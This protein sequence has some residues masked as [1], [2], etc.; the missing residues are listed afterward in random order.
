MLTRAGIAL[1]NA[2]A[3][4]PIAR[5]RAETLLGAFLRRV[6]EAR[7]DERW[8]HRPERVHLFGSFL[9]TDKPLV[10]DVDLV[11]VLAGRFL[12]SDEQAAANEAY[13]RGQE[14]AGRRF[15]FVD[16]LYAA[17]EDLRRFLRGRSPGLSLAA[18]STLTELAGERF[19]LLYEHPSFTPAGEAWLVRTEGGAAGQDRPAAAKPLTAVRPFD[20]LLP[21]QRGRAWV[22][23]PDARALHTALVD[24]ARQVDAAVEAKRLRFRRGLEARSWSRA[25]AAVRDADAA[26]RAA[27]APANHPNQAATDHID[28]LLRAAMLLDAA[29]TW[30]GDE[31]IAA[32]RGRS[33]PAAAFW[34]VRTVV[35]EIY[36]SG[37]RQRNDHL[38]AE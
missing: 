1:A 20:P 10:G 12:S 4:K 18:E 29:L 36:L 21:R 3:R 38:L 31:L 24:C 34:R 37:L 11:V 32:I 15:G 23:H 22:T 16:R 19:D 27:P 28:A 5:A 13:T 26:V 17:E 14:R 25:R 35:G 8:P 7:D 2:S 6:R 33:D 30:H 9:T